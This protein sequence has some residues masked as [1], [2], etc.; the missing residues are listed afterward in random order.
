MTKFQQIALAKLIHNLANTNYQNS[1]FYKSTPLCPLCKEHEETFQHV[2]QCRE[3]SASS[4]Q[5]AQLHTLESNLVN[6][7]NPRE[8]VR[9]I[10]HGFRDWQESRQ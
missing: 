10:L 2:L 1:L 8:I 7:Q 9:A 3:A 6:I 4:H 5:D